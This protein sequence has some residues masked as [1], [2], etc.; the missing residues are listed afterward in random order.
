VLLIV[1]MPALADPPGDA[2]LADVPDT[3]VR[4]VM[5]QPAPFAG[6]L[7]SPEENVR[8]A[9]KQSDCEATV[10]DAE[11]NGV[12]LPKPAVA[13][14]ISGAAAAVITSIVLGGLAAAHKL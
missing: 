4:L 8:R 11:A 1:A 6:R 12:L 14:L 13:A 10:A 5:G 7:L 3:S 9:K 2:P